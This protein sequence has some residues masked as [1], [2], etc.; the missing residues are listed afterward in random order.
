MLI[1]QLRVLPASLALGFVLHAMDD[2]R[3]RR[4]TGWPLQ[5]Y[6]LVWNEYDD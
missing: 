1:F 2:L 4:V 6:F 5:A 3:V